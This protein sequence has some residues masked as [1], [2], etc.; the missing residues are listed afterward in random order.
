MEETIEQQALYT[1]RS[2]ASL[3]VAASEVMAEMGFSAPV[4]VLAMHARV[5]PVT[6]FNH[7]GSKEAYLMEALAE[8][9]RQWVVRFHNGRREGESFLT[10]V[11][12]CRKLFRVNRDLSS[13][14]RILNNV[15]ED[16]SFAIAAIKP[17]LAPAVK[18]VVRNSDLAF[19]D[20]ELRLN[21]WS[22][23]VAGIFEGIFVAKELTPEQ[24][25]KALAI[26]LAIWNIPADQAETLTSQPLAY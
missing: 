20:F 25:D 3:L 4:E 24:A 6:I 19:N 5:S 7:F 9:W 16:P 11:D 17:T 26:S 18:D 21:L 23:C 2:R 1:E 14:G 12:V 15:L 10:M 13:L 8:T 22:L